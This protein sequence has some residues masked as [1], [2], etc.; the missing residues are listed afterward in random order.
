MLIVP[1]GVEY[2]GPAPA[3][4]E[5]LGRGRGRAAALPEW[6][7]G[8]NNWASAGARTASGKPA[9]RRRPPPAARHA[10]RATTRTTSPAPSWTRSGCRSPACP[11]CPTSATTARGVVRDPRWRTTRTCSSSASTDRPGALRVPGRVAARRG[12]RETIQVRGGR[13]GRDRRDGDAP[14]PGRAR[15]TAPRRGAVVPLHGDR[16]AQPHAG[17]LR[18][19]C[20]GPLRRRA[21]GGACGRGSTRQQPGVRRRPRGDRLPHARARAGAVEA[22][23]WLPVPAGTA[24]TSGRGRAVRGDARAARPGRRLH[25][26]RQRRRERTSIRTTS[27]STTRRTPGR[28]AWWR[29]SGTSRARPWRTWRP[30]T[31]TASRSRP[32]AC[33]AWPAASSPR[34]R[35]A[36]R[37]GRCCAGWDGVMDGDSAAAT[38]YAAFRERLVRDLLAPILGPL[39]AEAF[40]GAPGRRRP[41]GAA[42]RPARR[43]D[44][45]R[46]PDAAAAGRRLGGRAGPR[47]RAERSPRCATRW[48]RTRRRGPGAASTSP[49]APPA[50]GDVPGGGAAPRPAPP[51]RAATATPC[52]RRTS[53]PRRATT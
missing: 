36:R 26:H 48:G 12:T 31:P 20:C 15:R 42:A 30:S 11:G 33:G 2:R 29:A 52:R 47:A 14:R 49:A 1:P 21:R 44:P 24:P 3:A 51:W 40:A 13:A 23:A 28:A 16:R 22:N 38:V 19:R 43:E 5:A 41:H 32:G 7:D 17:G 6:E 18:S 50:V 45:R 34:R 4:L 27:A 37:R 9:R 25:R 39:A 35:A 46:R 8:S 53:S 10:Q